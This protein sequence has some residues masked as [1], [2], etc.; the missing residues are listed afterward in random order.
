MASRIASLALVHALYREHLVFG[1]MAL[2]LI[3]AVT[4]FQSLPGRS[5]VRELPTNRTRHSAA[6]LT[7]IVLML[8]VLIDYV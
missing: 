2:I 8:H 3:A 4:L 5:K 1:P 6:R 7:C